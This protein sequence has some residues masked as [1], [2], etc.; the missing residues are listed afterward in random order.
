MSLFVQFAY[1][2]YEE[3]DTC[4]QGIGITCRYRLNQ[5]T[6]DGSNGNIFIRDYHAC[7][8]KKEFCY[9]N[10]VTIIAEYICPPLRKNWD[11]KAFDL[12]SGKLLMFPALLEEY[13]PALHAIKLTKNFIKEISNKNLLPFKELE[14]LD[15]SYNQISRLD[16]N[17]FDNINNLKVV[18]FYYNQIKH[19]GHDIKFPTEVVGV[20]QNVCTFGL[21]SLVRDLNYFLL[22]HCPPLLDQIQMAINLRY[23]NKVDNRI[24]LQKTI[25]E[26]TH[27]NLT[28]SVPEICG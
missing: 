4:D 5:Y 2:T 27:L 8:A 12:I 14:I 7:I 23:S 15:L 17:L 9:R 6:F 19:I 25:P 18:A 22:V 16:T 26:T 11:V 10:E 13:F 20:E 24:I 28:S 21:N 1:C 3:V